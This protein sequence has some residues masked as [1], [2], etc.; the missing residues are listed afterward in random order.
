M[1]ALLALP[2]AIL[3]ALATFVAAVP[4]ILILINIGGPYLRAWLKEHVR[5]QELQKLHDSLRGTCVVVSAIAKAT[6]GFDADDGIAAILDGVTKEV[7]LALLEKYPNEA[8][9]YVGALHA[10]ERRPELKPLGKIEPHEV[11]NA[12][13]NIAE[14]IAKMG[15][16][17]K[18][19]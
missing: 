14:R 13:Q 11:P 3:I 6:V 7:G 19:R 17:A 9:A 5:K 18:A 12:I 2:P 15:S 8:A 1:P 4:T 16:G 10:D